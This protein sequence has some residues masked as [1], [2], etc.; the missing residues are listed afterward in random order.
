[1]T[2]LVQTSQKTLKDQTDNSASNYVTMWMEENIL[3]AR[4]ADNL[5]MTLE[6]AKSC[7]G[8]RVFFSK[9]ESYALLIDMKGI[10]SVT[11]EARTYMASFG[12][13]MVKAG[14]LITGSALNKTLGNIFLAIDKPPVPTKLFTSEEKAR[15]WLQQFV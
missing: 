14:A 13:L 8:A 10:K 6:I 11:P 9:G 5:H 3:C 7:V 15:E 4:Y 12:T 2:T 1:M